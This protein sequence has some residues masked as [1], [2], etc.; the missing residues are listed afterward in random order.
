MS[1]FWKRKS[2][3]KYSFASWL[4]GEFPELRKYDTE[5]LWDA[6]RETEYEVFY[7]DKKPVRLLVRLTMPIAVVFGLLM[8]LA[9]PINYI[10][11][12]KWGYSK[13][14]IRNWFEQIF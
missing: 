5:Q 10:I 6:L 2:A 11:T 9:S 13:L 8:I 7:L 4:K 14:W 3:D 1:F 12:G